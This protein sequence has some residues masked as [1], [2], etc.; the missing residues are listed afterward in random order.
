MSIHQLDYRFSGV[1]VGRI[2]VG[3]AVAAFQ[4]IVYQV[5]LQYNALR[6]RGVESW[7]VETPLDQWV[8][9]I[10]EFAFVYFLY[11]PG[12][13]IPALLDMPM[14]LFMRYALALVMAV[15]VSLLG[16]AFVPLRIDHEEYTCVEMA[17]MGLALLRDVDPGIN[18]LPSLHASQTLLA[19]LVLFTA[20]NA[21]G[22][23]SLWWFWSLVLYIP[24][25]IS[26][27]ANKQHFVI[28]L[29]AGFCVA[30]CV[31]VVSGVI[32]SRWARGAKFDAA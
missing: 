22:V 8:P 24:I 2:L 14:R 16:F 28:D 19:A 15:C 30:V 10:P 1:R 27:L 20:A 26:T 32:S 11:I 13:I 9:L 5:M 12:L 25:I 7:Q 3:V 4:L 23:R 6:L 31:W 21:H 17:C 29:V 18:L